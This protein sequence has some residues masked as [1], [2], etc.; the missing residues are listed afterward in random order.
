MNAI[1]VALGLAVFF[2]AELVGAN[3]AAVR[4]YPE[5]LDVYG[6]GRLCAAFAAADI[7]GNR[8]GSGDRA[9]AAAGGSERDAEQEIHLIGVALD[10]QAFLAPAGIAKLR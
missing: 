3:G 2:T 1:A 9:R 7:G 6:R 10:G 8:P 4:F 5:V